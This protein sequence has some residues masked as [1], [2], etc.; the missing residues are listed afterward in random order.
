MGTSELSTA[1]ITFNG[2]VGYPAGP[3]EKGV[4]NVVGIVLTYS[5]LT[6]GLSAAA[7]MIRAAR[8]AIA[9]ARRR[10]AFDVTISDFPMLKG[11]LETLDLFAK[12]TTAGAF[13]LYHDFLMLPEGLKGGL[14]TNEPDAVKRK[15][16]E[17]RELIM[18]QKIT[19]SW[20]ATDVLRLAMSVFGGHGVMEDFSS[21]PR[22]FRDAAIN[23]LWEGPRNV[24]L[25]QMHRDLSRASS[26]YDPADFVRNILA[27]FDRAKTESLA[28]RM[29]KLASSDLL[30]SGS[31]SMEACREWDVFCA[32]LFHAYQDRA[33][34]SIPSR[35]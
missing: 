34:A 9:Y 25:T 1:E 23:E 8:E 10:S 13:N 22:L 26:W 4:A 6:V 32:D 27:G 18:L 14:V 3:L 20:D 35:K 29:K 31:A 28:A 21:L 17:I 30:L 33:L 2:A 5:R 12:R 16:F 15:R 7:S 24:L 11:Q 19:A